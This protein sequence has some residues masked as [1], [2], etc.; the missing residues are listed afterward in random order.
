MCHF[1]S[2][3]KGL[4]SG[5]KNFFHFYLLCTG[6]CWVT[7]WQGTLIS[8]CLVRQGILNIC[9]FVSFPLAF[10]KSKGYIYEVLW[11]FWRNDEATIRQCLSVDVHE[12]SLYSKKLSGLLSTSIPVPQE[13]RGL[14]QG[15]E[16]SLDVTSMDEISQ[17]TIWL[18]LLRCCAHQRTFW[19]LIQFLRVLTVESRCPRI[20]TTSGLWNNRG[21]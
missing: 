9:V 4:C 6:W 14:H 20:T 3:S 8:T 12:G 1:L 18:P 19:W 11:L 13:W 5:K 10:L 16:S 2:F 21:E 7:R 17:E 15:K